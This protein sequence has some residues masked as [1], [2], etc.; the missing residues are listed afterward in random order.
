MKDEQIEQKLQLEC[1]NAQVDFNGAAKL[2]RQLGL[3]WEVRKAEWKAEESKLHDE[4]AT[5]WHIM[6]KCRR[7]LKDMGSEPRDIIADAGMERLVADVQGQKM[8]GEG[9]GN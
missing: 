4:L 5:R 6:E 1:L 7:H 2:V 3:D 8:K 9:G